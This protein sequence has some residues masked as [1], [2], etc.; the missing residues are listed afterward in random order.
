MAICSRLGIQNFVPRSYIEQVQMMQ[1][2]QDFAEITDKARQHFTTGDDGI[3]DDHVIGASPARRLVFSSLPHRHSTDDSLLALA[4]AQKPHRSITGWPTVSSDPTLSGCNNSPRKMPPAVQRVTPS[5]LSQELNASTAASPRDIEGIRCGKGSTL[6]L[7]HPGPGSS[8]TQSCAS[9]IR[10]QSPKPNTNGTRT[11]FRRQNSTD[12]GYH[13]PSWVKDPDF[14]VPNRA[15]SCDDHLL[16]V[17]KN[18]SD[19]LDAAVDELRVIGTRVQ[20][21][22]SLFMGVAMGFFLGVVVTM[23][24]AR[25]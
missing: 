11:A 9:K 16:S 4:T 20:D 14:W 23:V 7:D 22:R 25:R 21:S 1:L 5:Q 12:S 6:V 3:I 17:L 18:V 19:H 13:R 2:T 24:S 8:K 15:A 10:T